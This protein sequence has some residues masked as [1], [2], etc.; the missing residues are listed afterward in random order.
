[1]NRRLGSHLGCVFMSLVSR[2]LAT[3]IKLI[4]PLCMCRCHLL[5]QVWRNPKLHLIFTL[6]SFKWNVKCMW[7]SWQT[8]PIELLVSVK[9][10]HCCYEWHVYVLCGIQGAS[11][12]CSGINWARYEIW[13]RCGTH[14]RVSSSSSSRDVTGSSFELGRFQIWNPSDSYTFFV[15]F[16]VVYNYVALS[17]LIE[18][19]TR[20]LSF[21][22]KQNKQ[23][24]T[25]RSYA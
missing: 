14:S 8:W 19:A 11:V 6:V 3:N 17:L 7:L 9:V 16:H 5:T 24:G 15:Q 12:S 23:T 1:M 20:T 22:M 2:D 21:W 18:C 25:A 13:R 4:P 10:A